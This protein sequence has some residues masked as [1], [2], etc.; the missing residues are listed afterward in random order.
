MN[1]TVTLKQQPT[2]PVVVI[3]HSNTID[4]PNE[5]RVISMRRNPPRIDCSWIDH[6]WWPTWSRRSNPNQQ[7]HSFQT[8]TEGFRS[9][10]SQAR[11][12]AAETSSPGRN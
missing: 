4:A 12:V 9:C 7:A 10:L 11:T 8:T 5:Y 1:I 6:R 2:T 3:W